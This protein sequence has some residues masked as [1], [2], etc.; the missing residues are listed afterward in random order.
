MYLPLI[1]NPFKNANPS[2]QELR[3]CGHKLFAEICSY[4]L[5]CNI[6]SSAN[7]CRSK[8]LVGQTWSTCLEDNKNQVDLG[9][10]NEHVLIS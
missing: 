6:I 2:V 1:E 7:I 8:R 4:I 9:G 3:I 5:Q 10:S